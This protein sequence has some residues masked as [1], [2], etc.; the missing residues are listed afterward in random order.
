MDNPFSKLLGS[1]KLDFTKKSQSVVGIDIGS[2]FVKVVQLKKKSGRAVL[3]T[4][5]ELAL[6]PI[7]G[8]DVGRMTN[9]PEEKVAQAVA[10]ILREANVT[11]KDCA[12]AIP[13]SGSL[14]SFVEIPYLVEKQ[15]QEIIPIEARKY[16]PVPISEVTLDW[17]IIPKFDSATTEVSEPE[18]AGSSALAKVQKAD[19]LIAAIHNDVLTKLK[20]VTTRNGLI[21]GFF[22]IEVFSTVR[23]TFGHDLMPTMLFDVG[24]GMTKLSIVE[25]G[26]VQSVHI[27]NRGSQDIT[28]NISNSLGVSTSRA[29]ELKRLYGLSET[30]SEEGKVVAEISST[31]LEYVFSEANRILLNYER[32][33]SK[34]VSR[35]ILI[36]GGVLLKGF[37]EAAAKRLEAEIV[38]GDPFSKVEAPAFLGDVLKEAGP[39]FAVAIGLALRRL[40]ELE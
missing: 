7:A 29:E 2:S 3:E 34:T 23:S 25:R 36:G 24:A 38:Y 28:L 21:P 9:L 11:T 22:E 30:Q 40:Q 6:G 35:V 8:L 10:D 39:E 27:V 33:Y 5:G 17:W 12:V 4:Y 31:V 15:L 26:V 18:K 32:K 16:I 14:I 1:L 37:R 20:G 13:L 19:V